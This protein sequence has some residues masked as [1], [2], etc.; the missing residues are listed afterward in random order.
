MLPP[1]DA[2]G[3]APE[4]PTQP[5]RRGG[6]SMRT[7]IIAALVGLLVL[8]AIAAVAWSAWKDATLNL[9]GG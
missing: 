1:A 6:L 5:Q 7:R 2:A 9:G 3:E 4:R 8:L